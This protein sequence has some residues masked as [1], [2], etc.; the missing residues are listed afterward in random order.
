M[1]WA[2]RAFPRC[3]I[4]SRPSWES[5]AW[6]SSSPGKKR[7]DD[8]IGRA[9]K[10]AFGGVLIAN[11]GFTKRERR[12][13]PGRVAARMPWRSARRIIANPDL[14]QRFAEGAG[15]QRNGA[16]VDLRKGRDRVFG[17]SRA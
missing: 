8:S 9:L 16:S 10:K 3:S 11:E 14:V 12:G 5:A 15:P 4:T 2:I 7:R 17:L 6:P 13:N 1:T